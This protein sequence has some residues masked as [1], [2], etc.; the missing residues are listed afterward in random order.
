M[1]W[2]PLGRKSKSIIC[3]DRATHA[4]SSRKKISQLISFR[5]IGFLQQVTTFSPQRR[6]GTESWKQNPF[7][8]RLGASAVKKVSPT[9]FCLLLSAYCLLL[10]TTAN[11]RTNS[12]LVPQ[13]PPRKFAPAASNAGAC[14]VKASGAV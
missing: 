14:L 8:L 6:G 2:S 13:H 11:A 12:G 5:R 4:Q 7:F 1:S 9:A 10:I 3:G